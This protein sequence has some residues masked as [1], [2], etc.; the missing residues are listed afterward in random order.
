[1][2]LSFSSKTFWL[3]SFENPDEEK[4]NIA[5]IS[6]P[7]VFNAPQNIAPPSSDSVITMDLNYNQS[8]INNSNGSYDNVI[9]TVDIVSTTDFSENNNDNNNNNDKNN[10]NDNENNNDN[11]GGGNESASLLNTSSPPSAVPPTTSGDDGDNNF[12]N[13]I[14][15]GN[16]G[17]TGEITTSDISTSEDNQMVISSNEPE[18]N[19][20]LE[21]QGPSSDGGET[22]TMKTD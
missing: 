12:T 11:G 1:M 3:P 22:D 10:D 9:G 7:P 21:A 19:Q 20:S 2:L 6:I 16:T 15:N 5:D 18:N 14:D 17:N 13:V 8:T 4:E